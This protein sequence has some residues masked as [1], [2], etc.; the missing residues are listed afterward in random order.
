MLNRNTVYSC[1]LRYLCLIEIQVF[2]HLCLLEYTSSKIYLNLKSTYSTQNNNTIKYCS[3]SIVT[4]TVTI[5]MGSAV[6]VAMYGWPVMLSSWRD[7]GFQWQ[8]NNS[9]N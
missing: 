6:T 8:L 5:C 4:V 2:K 1:V 9:L 3:G 7:G